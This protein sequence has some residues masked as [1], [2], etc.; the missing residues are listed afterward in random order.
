[1][2]VGIALGLVLPGLATGLGGLALLAVGRRPSQ[3]TMAAVLGFTGG[4][5]LAATSFSLLVPALDQGGVGTVSLGVVAGGLVMLALDRF[6]PHEH[7]DRDESG[8]AAPGEHRS[9][10]WLLVSALTIHNIPEGLAVGLAFAAG[11]MDAGLPVALAIGIQNAPEGFAAGAPLLAAGR[12]RGTAVLVAVL[13]GV[14]EP[15][16]AL[17]GYGL[18]SAAEGLLVPGLAFA[19]GAMLYVTV[20]ELLPSAQAGGRERLATSSLMAGFV[21]LLVLDNALG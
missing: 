19:G 13:S 15:L 4:V 18:S 5:M 20:D 10:P 12:A 2:D 9:R 7:D 16:A 17:A 6:V 8:C 11:G 1:M 3:R 14:V 21:L